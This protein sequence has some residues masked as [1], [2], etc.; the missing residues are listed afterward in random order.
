MS[1]LANALKILSMFGNDTP[2]LRVTEVAE[3][4]GLPKSSV[5]RLIKELVASGYLERVGDGRGFMPGA[6]LL[7]LGQLYR[8][9]TPLED[10]IDQACK[11]FLVTY[12]A[13]G[14]VC[15]L[16]G[17]DVVVIRKHE[18]HHQLR[19]IV[20][21]GTVVPAFASAVGKAL[22]AH[23]PDVEVSARLPDR[24]ST[25]F[26]EAD[27]EKPELMDEICLIRERG[28]ATMTDHRM[29]IGAIGVAISLTANRDMGF[30]ICYGLD[31]LSVDGRAELATKLVSAAAEIGQLAGDEYWQ[32]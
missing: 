4:I 25:S 7:R 5:S 3:K 26:R 16:R 19:Y 28:Y 22:L 23:L 1:S 2:S 8:T 32:S 11:D 21:P 13:T 27:Y 10:R 29:R 24:M 20:E 9:G 15:V 14:Y 30:A 31:T 18:G 17:I 6:E 12:P